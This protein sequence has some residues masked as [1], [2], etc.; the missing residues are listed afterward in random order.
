MIQENY[1]SHRYSQI[2]EGIENLTKTGKYEFLELVTLGLEHI[3]TT[4]D[5]QLDH[6]YLTVNDLDLYFRHEK[7]RISFLF[8]ENSGSEDISESRRTLGILGVKDHVWPD[9]TTERLYRSVISV[10][11]GG[12]TIRNDVWITQKSIRST[13]LVLGSNFLNNNVRVELDNAFVL[14]DK[15]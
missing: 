5:P 13:D 15:Q 9:G 7:P 11:L 3:A 10:E 14:G 2:P 1:K 12:N 6:S 8:G 4:L